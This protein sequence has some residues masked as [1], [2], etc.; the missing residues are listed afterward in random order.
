MTDIT[1]AQNDATNVWGILVE[2]C[3]EHLTKVLL[4]DSLSRGT[5]NDCDT[6]GDGLDTQLRV[7]TK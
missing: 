1:V 7:I 2:A 6:L 5:E 3:T 4:D